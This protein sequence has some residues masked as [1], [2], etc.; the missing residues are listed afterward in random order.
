MSFTV[1]QEKENFDSWYTGEAFKEAHGGGSIWGFTDMLINALFTL[2]GAPKP[3][4]WQAVLPISMPGDMSGKR[5]EEGW[6]VVEADGKNT[7]PAECFVVM[8]RF[9][10]VPGGEEAFEQ[11]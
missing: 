1:W 4:F 3:A 5:V 6:R 8:N 7:L 10:V 9:Q 11:R 2:N